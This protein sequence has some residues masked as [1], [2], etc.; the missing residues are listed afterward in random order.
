MPRVHWDR[1]RHVVCVN[2]LDHDEKNSVHFILYSMMNRCRLSYEE[3]V[4]PFR[5]T[6][7]VKPTVVL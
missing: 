7:I 3:E 5:E 2:D 1:E 6:L 4:D